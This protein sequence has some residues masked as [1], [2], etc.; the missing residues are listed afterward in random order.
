MCTLS[1]MF[2]EKEKNRTNLF[3]Q[4]LDFIAENLYSGIFGMGLPLSRRIELVTMRYFAKMN[5]FDD[6]ITNEF[7]DARRM[8]EGLEKSEEK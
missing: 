4:Q 3:E 2:L 6:L 8:L 5:A 1:E 7:I